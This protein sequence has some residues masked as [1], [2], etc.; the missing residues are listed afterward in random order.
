MNSTYTQAVLDP[1][2]A[3]KNLR[4]DADFIIMHNLAYMTELQSRKGRTGLSTTERKDI[5]KQFDLATD[6][7][8]ESCQSD[9]NFNA[10]MT[11]PSE[12]LA[13]RR[14]EA[15]IAGY[16]ISKDSEARLTFRI[17]EAL[18]KWVTSVRDQFS[19]EPLTG[20]SDGS[21]VVSVSEVFDNNI[22]TTLSQPDAGSSEHEP[23]PQPRIPTISIKQPQNARDSSLT[24]LVLLIEHNAF[25]KS[26]SQGFQQL[27]HMMVSALHALS[28]LGIY[29][30]PIFGLGTVGPV[31]YLT[32]GWRSRETQVHRST[33]LLLFLFCISNST[34]IT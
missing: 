16:R 24:I 18:K 23:F 30:F 12:E 17:T 27:R 20:R 26:V 6:F 7:Y 2:V 34:S 5:T 11:N 21:L 25:L 13:F 31:G 19:K 29:N 14:K 28:I 3:L 22:R 1:L 4:D 10:L 32:M 33:A 15:R 8:E 9:S